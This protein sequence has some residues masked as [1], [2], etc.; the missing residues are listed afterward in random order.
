MSKPKTPKHGRATLYV[1]DMEEWARFKERCAEQG[2]SPS[3][4]LAKLADQWDRRMAR[5]EAR[6][7]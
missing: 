6:K 5:R 4:Q 1:P 3:M 7:A 2:I